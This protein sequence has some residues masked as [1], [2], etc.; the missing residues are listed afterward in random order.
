M[1]ISKFA[2]VVGAGLLACACSSTHFQQTASVQAPSDA[3]A[4]D[5]SFRPD[6]GDYVIGPQ[7][8][9]DVQVFGVPALSGTVQVDNTGYVSLPLLGRVKASG[10][11]T[12]ELSKRIAAELNKKYVKD[13]IVTVTTKDAASQK[14]TVA[15]SVSKPGLYQIRPNTTLTQAVA[16]A[17]GP[18]QVADIHEVA[19][20]RNSPQGRQVKVYDLDDINGGKV[21]DPYVHANDEV[22]VNVSGARKFVRDFGGAFGILGWLHP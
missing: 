13:P 17:S 20:I 19:I 7:D 15:G 14:I 5:A 4:T 11:T 6:N 21:T 22:V 2:F 16:M 3:T 12:N 1:T 10:R 9:L 8:A 18:D